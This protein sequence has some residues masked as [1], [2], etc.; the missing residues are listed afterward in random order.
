MN[1]V[2]KVTRRHILAGTLTFVG[3]AA[4]AACSQTPTP[5]PTPATQ[6]AA[7]PAT[8]A[9][10]VS[11]KTVEITYW[12]TNSGAMSDAEVKILDRFNTTEGPKLG[13]SVVHQFVPT[14][15]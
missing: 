11:S 6:A 2:R 10:A 7:P 15:P 12:R 3:A 8:T 1:R 5:Q 14:F 4:L 9:P 13:I